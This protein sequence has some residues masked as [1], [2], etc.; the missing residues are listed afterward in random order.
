MKFDAKG[1][2]IVQQTGDITSN[3]ISIDAANID[4]IVTILSTNLYSQPIQSLIRETVSNAWDSHIEAK[5]ADP[6]ILELGQDSEEEYYY[7]I[8]DFG[9]GL[10]EDRFNNIFRNVGSSTKRGTNNQ[11]GGFGIGRFSVLAYSDVVYLTSHFDGIKYQYIM[12]KDSNKISID[13]LHQETTTQRNGFKVHVPIKSSTDLHFFKRAIEQQLIYF[14][15]VYFIDKTNYYAISDFS[16]SFNSLKIKRYKNFSVN[17]LYRE[18]E[19]NLT[20]GKVA[21]PLRFG[22]LTENYSYRVKEYPVTLRFEIGELEVTPNREELLYSDHNVK[23]IEAKI[24]AMLEEVEELIEAEDCDHTDFIEYYKSLNNHVFTLLEDDK[25][26]IVIV[27][28]NNAKRMTFN[29]VK[30]NG[31][32]VQNTYRTMTQERLLSGYRL[33]SGKFLSRGNQ[34]ITINTLY[35]DVDN[36]PGKYFIADIANL[37]ALEKAYVKDTVPEEANFFTPREQYWK[38]RLH[39]LMERSREY[40]GSQ[41]AWKETKLILNE[42]IFPI[43]RKIP[44]FDQKLIPKSWKTKRKAEQMANR[45]A[46]KRKAFSKEEFTVHKMRKATHGSSIVSDSLTVTMQKLVTSKGIFV[47][48]EKEDEYLDKMF[49]TMKEIDQYNYR[50][51]TNSHITFLR[52][53]PTRM[54]KLELIPNC[55]KAKD[56]MRLKYKPIRRIATA[57]LIQKELPFLKQ[58]S[59]LTNVD[60]ISV[61][62]HDAIRKLQEYVDK[63]LNTRIEGLSD[64]IFT[65]CQD[66]NYF[67]EEMRSYLRVHKDL[68]EKAQFLLFMKSSNSNSYGSYNQI[69]EERFNLITDYILARKLFRPNLD[70][71]YKLKKETVLN[72]KPE[73]NED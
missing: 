49:I 5:V 6:V 22:A 66:H 7:S 55:I 21:Y 62:V 8:E 10:S 9:V 45:S 25:T 42:V 1:K 39:I 16:E 48:G 72:L 31:N 12:Y 13:L 40:N 28:S 59:Y 47:Y 61:K 34:M 33:K 46:T 18:K 27:N 63:H 54:K 43:L 2:S 35:N 58:I 24:A 64:E 26:P 29:G 3:S 44:R 19:I 36:I 67:D 30:Y 4:F 17:T 60:E 32:L 38:D 37:T 73:E 57:M 69:P 23:V 70:A 15:N 41:Y 11:I 71:F 20:L 50:T 68:L 53:A 65:M 52:M 14:E 56:F 51:H